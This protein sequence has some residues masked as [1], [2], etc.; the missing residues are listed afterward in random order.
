MRHWLPASTS[1]GGIAST[2]NLT[3]SALGAMVHQL[4]DDGF[5]CG[6]RSENFFGKMYQ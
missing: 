4:G 5:A 2:P 3:G 1:D 6:A